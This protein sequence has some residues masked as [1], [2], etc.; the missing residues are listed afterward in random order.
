MA[1]CEGLLLLYFESMG[2][3]CQSV[4]KVR[5]ELGHT[6]TDL[7]GSGQPRHLN[8]EKSDVQSCFLESRRVGKI[9]NHIEIYGICH[10]GYMG[11]ITYPSKCCQGSERIVFPLCAPQEEHLLVQFSYTTIH[12]RL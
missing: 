8:E 5:H 6:M 11:S 3:T 9:C 2:S 10:D 1:E 4:K 12:Q 7:P